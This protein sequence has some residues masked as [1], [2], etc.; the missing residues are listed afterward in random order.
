MFFSPITSSLIPNIKADV[1]YSFSKYQWDEQ[2]DELKY[3][4]YTEEVFVISPVILSFLRY[5][6]FNHLLIIFSTG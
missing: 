2:K 4:Q 3:F 1:Y 5:I 6:P